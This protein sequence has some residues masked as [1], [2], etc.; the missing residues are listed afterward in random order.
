MN[1]I[2]I[3][4]LLLILVMAFSMLVSCGVEEVNLEDAVERTDFTSVYEKIGAKITLIW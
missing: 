3:L 4:S 1:K 2:R